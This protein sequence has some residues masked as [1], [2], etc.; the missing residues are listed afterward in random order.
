MVEL[1]TVYV[2]EMHM[3][4]IVNFKPHHAFLQIVMVAGHAIYQVE[5]AHVIM[6][7]VAALLLQIAHYV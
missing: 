6:D 4:V 5:F 3:E 7:M 2:M 1:A